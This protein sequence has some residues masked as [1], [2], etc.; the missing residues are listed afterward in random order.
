[1]N[2]KP[3]TWKII[4]SI[5]LGIIL[6]YVFFG[7]MFNVIPSEPNQVASELGSSTV[8]SAFPSFGALW[9]FYILSAVVIYVIW[10]LIQKKQ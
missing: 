4:L 6:G 9:M 8:V 1:M 10:S 3:T 2:F 5:V 7:L